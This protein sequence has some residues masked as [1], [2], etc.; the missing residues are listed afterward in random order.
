[1]RE[2]VQ[3]I[4]N[5]CVDVW[6]AH[7]DV[8]IRDR[9][10]KLWTLPRY[11]VIHFEAHTLANG[12]MHAAAKANSLAQNGLAN[13]L[14]VELFKREEC[15][16]EILGLST[17]GSLVCVSLFCVSLFLRLIVSSKGIWIVVSF[18]SQRSRRE[19]RD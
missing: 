11:R 15:R 4:P 10:A 18:H 13:E 16:P 9:L 12:Q 1:M 3:W 8:P 5:V 7:G 6:E 14:L 19:S 17:C 2:A